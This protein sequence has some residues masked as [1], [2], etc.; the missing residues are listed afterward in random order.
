M[1]M[2][3][4]RATRP[5]SFS[6]EKTRGRKQFTGDIT[7]TWANEVLIDVQ[8]LARR[9]SQFGLIHSAKLVMTD[10]LIAATAPL[11]SEGRRSDQDSRGLRP[12]ATAAVS[13]NKAE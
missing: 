8:G 2:T 7:G 9:S 13:A 12:M 1:I 5:G 11:S 10:K 6:P 4:G 3:T